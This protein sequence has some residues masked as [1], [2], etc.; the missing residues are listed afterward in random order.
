MR[1]RERERERERVCERER[2]SENLRLRDFKSDKFLRSRIRQR[3]NV[4]EGGKAEIEIEV[5]KKDGNES[6][7][8][9][10]LQDILRKR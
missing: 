9:Q 4:E 6:I 8:R 10:C 1:E 5:G 7:D 2:E 3:D